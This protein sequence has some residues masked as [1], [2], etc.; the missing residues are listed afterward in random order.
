MYLSGSGRP[1]TLVA[2]DNTDTNL[3]DVTDPARLVIDD[4]NIHFDTSRDAVQAA[5]LSRAVQ[6]LVEDAKASSFNHTLAVITAPVS[7]RHSFTV[8]GVLIPASGSSP[9]AMMAWA[10]YSVNGTPVAVH[11]PPS[12][13]LVTNYPLF[14]SAELD[15][16]EQYTLTAE[17]WASPDSPYVFD[18]LLAFSPKA[19]AYQRNN[20]PAS[21]SEATNSTLTPASISTPKSTPLTS[22]ST[23]TPTSISTTTSSSTSTP[24]LGSGTQSFPPWAIAA[25]VIVGAVTVLGLAWL[26]YQSKRRSERFLE[27]WS[28]YTQDLGLTTRPHPAAQAANRCR[29]DYP[30]APTPYQAGAPACYVVAA[31]YPVCIPTQAGIVNAIAWQ[32]LQYAPGPAFPWRSI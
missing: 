1:S 2:I 19:P 4:T 31:A 13:A 15:T 22:T 20:G 32:P 21:F 30:F 28:P 24:V 26:I 18:Y 3:V 10:N 14:T 27:R 5:T 8:Y 6:N 11:I 16:N 23:P 29:V 25:L 17:I 12:A 9:P 7:F